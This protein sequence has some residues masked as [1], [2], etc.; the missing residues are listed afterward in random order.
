M[1]GYIGRD[2]I[3]Q[4]HGRALLGADATLLDADVRE[5]GTVLADAAASLDFGAP[6][7]VCLVNVLHLIPDDP[8]ALVRRY[9]DACAPGSRIVITHVSRDG[10]DP[11]LLGR[12]E[13]VFAGPPAARLR[14]RA[15]IRDLFGDLP[16]LEPG[17]VD[18]AAWRPE[19]ETP[20]GRLR[21][22]AGVASVP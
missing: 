5:A 13:K 8:G 17:L 22:F 14:T 11:E 18:V 1:S 7:C 4:S 2:N 15:E 6:V 10:A 9:A 3:V 20:A 21:V 19:E 12:I 16:M